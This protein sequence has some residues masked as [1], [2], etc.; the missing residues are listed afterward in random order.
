MLDSANVNY[1]YGSLQ[2]VFDQTFEQTG[3]YDLP[4]K[5]ALILGFGSGSV[6]ELLLTKCDPEMKI[7]G[8]EAD[9][10]VIRLTKQYFPVARN[11]NVT[12][13]HSDAAD[14]IVSSRG[15]YDLIIIDVFIEAIVP[16]KCQSV[17]FL[18]AV[19][20]HL[21]PTGKLYFNKMRME[22]DKISIEDFEKNLRAVFDKIEKVKLRRGGGSNF[23]FVAGV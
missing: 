16:E 8:V 14:Y 18:R 22:S 17:E 4:V 21:S 7:T 13:V 20:S 12:I 3:L 11:S 2:E 23:V 6:A 19:K 10:E 15:S 1:S 5:S 9:S